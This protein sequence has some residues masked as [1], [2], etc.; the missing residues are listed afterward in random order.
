MRI[1]VIFEIGR[2]LKYVKEND[3]TH[4][5]WDKWCE[6]TLDITRQQANKY[7][8][9]FNEFSNGKTTYQLG[10]DALYLISALP[11]KERE[12]IHTIPSTGEQKMIDE[13]TVCELR[14]VKKSIV[15]TT[16]D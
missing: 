11:G 8:K 7:V 15:A 16:K 9:V 13:M 14:E 4:G 2:R 1:I 6:E 12:K 5:Q 3:L 10:I